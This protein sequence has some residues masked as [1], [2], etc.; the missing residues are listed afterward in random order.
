MLLLSDQP[1]EKKSEQ[2]CAIAKEC[3]VLHFFFLVQ[4]RRMATA[5]RGTGASTCNFVQGSETMVLE[6]PGVMI[7][8]VE[9]R[10][11]PLGE[12]DAHLVRYCNVRRMPVEA[13]G[14]GRRCAETA[15]R[16][17]YDLVRGGCLCPAGSGR[18]RV[19]PRCLQNTGR[20]V[21]IPNCIAPI[22]SGAAPSA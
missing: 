20:T 15:A 1:K 9:V 11:Y 8:D 14:A 19:F 7:S 22:R 4:G 18:P 17:G 16:F 5:A 3:C 2:V 13:D 6:I 21:S 10:E 12:A